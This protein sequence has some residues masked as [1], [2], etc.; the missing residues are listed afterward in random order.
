DAAVDVIQKG[1]TIV[2]LGVF[3]EKPRIDMS[4][5]ASTP[6]HLIR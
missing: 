4:I 3:G 2:V 5:T 1:G 6:L